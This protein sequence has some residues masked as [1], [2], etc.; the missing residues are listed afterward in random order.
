MKIAFV[1]SCLDSGG[2]S[3]RELVLDCLNKIKCSNG[4][5]ANAFLLVNEAEALASAD[6]QDILRKAVVPIGPLAGVTISIK[7]LFDVVGQVTTSGSKVLRANAP[8]LQDAEVIAKLRQA[9][10][11]FMGRTNMTEF[12]YS[13]LGINP[14][15]GT[16]LNPFDRNTQRISGG[17]T[18]GGAISVS[19]GMVSIALGSDTGGSCRIPAALCGLVGY[20]STARRYSMKGVLPLSKS[21]DSIGVIASSVDCCRRVDGVLAEASTS[22]MPS[23]ALK[24]L[25]V[26][27]LRNEVLNGM[28]EVVERAYLKALNALII[29]GVSIHTVDSTIISEVVALQGQQKIVS[30]EAYANLEGVMTKSFGDIDPRVSSRISKGKEVSSATYIQIV[31]ERA[32]LIAMWGHEFSNDD[33][34]IMPTVPVIAP[35]MSDFENDNEYF[36]LNGLILRNPGIFNFLD[37]CAISIPCHGLESAPVGL[38]LVSPGGNDEKLLAIAS[39]LESVISKITSV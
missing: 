11:I 32:R 31:N 2:V 38:M 23:I 19:D 5:G 10:S 30:V 1:Q 37:G 3:T 18:S 35:K 16:P 20:K 29:A 27:V 21:L 12:A 15:Y 4:Q 13:G 36:R 39:L 9:G 7:D 22:K 25:K 34:W 6:S 26:G 28:D 24:N 14:H 33:I 17:S 8:A